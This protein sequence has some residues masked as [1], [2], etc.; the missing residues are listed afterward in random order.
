VVS[1]TLCSG[2]C[3]RCSCPSV[4]TLPRFRVR[5]CTCKR[6][7]SVSTGTGGVTEPG[8]VDPGQSLRVVNDDEQEVR[9]DGNERNIER[10]AAPRARREANRNRGSEDAGNG[11][12][13]AACLILKEALGDEMTR[14]PWR[15]P[16]RASEE[17]GPLPQRLR[18]DHGEGDLGPVAVERP[19]L[20]S[21]EGLRFE[22]RIVGQGV[23]R[24][25]RRGLSLGDIEAAL[26]ATVE[27]Q[28]FSK[29]SA[30]CICK[31]TRSRYRASCRWRFDEH[32]LAYLFLDALY[33]KLRP[34]DDPAKGVLCAWGITVEH[35]K[36][37]RELALGSRESYEDWLSFG[38]GLVGRPSY[39]SANS[40]PQPRHSSD[41][42]ATQSPRPPGALL[43]EVAQNS[44]ARAGSTP[45]PCRPTKGPHSYQGASPR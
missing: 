21:A 44:N 23:A 34:E 15:P 40:R 19:R 29:S 12:R 10:A 32:L 9:P 2:W 31:D 27:E 7:L 28:V 16:L 24:E 41:S 42:Q 18:A 35:R 14:V 39:A 17:T 20:R 38:R 5:R 30:S 43:T 3:R 22:S 1:A 36:V 33:L 25:T 26:R 8:K 4:V 45:H 37:L 13:F 11:S 6:G